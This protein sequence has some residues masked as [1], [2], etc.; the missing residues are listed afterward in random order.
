MARRAQFRLT[1]HW[2]IGAEFVLGANL[3]CVEFGALVGSS[4]NAKMGSLGLAIEGAPIRHQVS[5][6]PTRPPNM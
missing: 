3:H 2:F 5:W 1:P 6:A 4:T